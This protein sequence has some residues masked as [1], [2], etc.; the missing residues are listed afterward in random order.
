VIAGKPADDDAVRRV[1]GLVALARA[2]D[3][4]AQAEAFAKAAG[5]LADLAPLRGDAAALAAAAR[6]AYRATF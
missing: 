3:S 5:T 6:A 1:R 2:T 4:R